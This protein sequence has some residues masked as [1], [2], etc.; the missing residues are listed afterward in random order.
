MGMKCTVILVSVQVIQQGQTYPLLRPQLQLW[1]FHNESELCSLLLYGSDRM[2][3]LYNFIHF[4]AVSL[5]A[6][7]LQGEKPSN[8][9]LLV[10]HSTMKAYVSRSSM[11]GQYCSVHSSVCSGFVHLYLI[12]KGLPKLNF[13]TKLTERTFLVQGHLKQSC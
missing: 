9:F 12:C 2:R 4:N 5:S 3:L 6:T 11:H 10:Q 1:G 7:C 13:T 8:T